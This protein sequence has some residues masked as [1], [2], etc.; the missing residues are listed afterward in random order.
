VSAVN[1]PAG[2]AVAEVLLAV[3]ADVALRQYEMVKRLD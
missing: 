1:Y 2:G 3:G